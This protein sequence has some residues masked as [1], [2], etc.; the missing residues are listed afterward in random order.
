MCNPYY[1][2]SAILLAGIDG[3]KNK[4]DPKD[5]NWGPFDFNLYELT[6]KQ[7]AKLDKLPKTLD[8][9]IE[10]LRKDNDYLLVDDVFTKDL[11]ES[12]INVIS[13]DADKVNRMPHP[14]EFELYYNL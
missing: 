5:Y 9:A 14:A 3:I 2:Y 6:D 13:K 1:A 8:E 7:K 12:W 4:I 10:A 11:I